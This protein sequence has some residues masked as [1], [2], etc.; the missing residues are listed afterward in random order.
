MRIGELALATNTKV[1]AIRY[2]EAE[3]LLQDVTRTSTNR[4]TYGQA[5]L[6]RLTFIRQA[7][8]L[9]F[10][11]DEVRSLL[12]LLDDPEQPCA[13]ATTIAARHLSDVKSK[14]AQLTRM[15]RELE[16]MSQN[17][18]GGKV[19]HCEILDAL[20]RRNGLRGP[21]AQLDTTL[22]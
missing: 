20:T 15:K 13:E 4:R 12:T 21:V 14:I 1:P 16:R 18:S 2:Y 9:G 5:E 3:G 22:A 7:R 19:S 8:G 6:R 17:C 10:S 11:L